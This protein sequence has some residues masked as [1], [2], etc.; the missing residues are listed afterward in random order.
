MDTTSAAPDAPGANPLDRLVLSAAAFDD[1]QR[2]SI[3]IEMPVLWAT[4]DGHVLVEGSDLDLVAE[5]LGHAAVDPGEAFSPEVQSGRDLS[6]VLRA[7]SRTRSALDALEARTV[8][9]LD[10]DVRCTDARSGTPSDRQGRRSAHEVSMAIRTSPAAASR[11]V[12]S[13]RRLVQDM[14]ATLAALAEGRITG[15]VAHTIGRTVGVLDRADRRRT[16]EL[17]ADHLPELEGASRGQW[18]RE[19]EAIAYRLAPQKHERREGRARHQ[20][21]ITITRSE[22]GM[23]DLHAHLPAL[24]AMAI[25][26]KLSLHAEAARAEG[27]RRGHG[28]LMVD[29]F[30][31]TLLGREDGMDPVHLDVGVIITDRTLF[32]PDEGEPAVLEGYGTLPPAQLRDRLAASDT[33]TDMDEQGDVIR[34]MYTHPTPSQL[35]AVE[36]RARAFPAP[37]A[38]MIRSRDQVCRTPHCGAPIRQIDHVTP[39]SRGGPTSLANGAGLCARCNSIKEEAAEVTT[40]GRR[41]TWRTRLGRSAWTVPARLETPDPRATD[42]RA[43]ESRAPDPR[44]PDAP[45]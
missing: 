19:V 5:R 2:A 29:H 14:P 38:R 25:R 20:R 27:D 21:S 8:V 36:S 17:L 3:L 6:E 43:T 1:Q 13:S 23:A 44:A 11:R 34:W 39:V 33:R 31:D 12:N 4:D 10:E 40:D 22:H 45:T 28:R 16:D 7:I 41:V 37:L 9:A 26:K 18:G 15:D 42:S 30:T 35:V 32:H 24:D